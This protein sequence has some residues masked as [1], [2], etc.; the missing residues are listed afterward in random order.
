MA[1]TASLD[2]WT[3]NAFLDTALFLHVSSPG[4]PP[5]QCGSKHHLFWECPD[6]PESEKQRDRN[7]QQ[8]A[9]E[10]SRDVES[11]DDEKSTADEPHAPTDTPRSAV[12][13]SGSVTVHATV[14]GGAVSRRVD[15]EAKRRKPDNPGQSARGERSLCFTV[16]LFSGYDVRDL[17]V[18]DSC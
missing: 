2:G 7:K 4:L 8:T 11:S 16:R 5:K 17:V 14:D 3:D 13:K 18:R 9:V 10:A 1:V 12:G 6:R 15:R